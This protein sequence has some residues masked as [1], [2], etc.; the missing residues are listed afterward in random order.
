MGVVRSSRLPPSL[1]GKPILAH[2]QQV[3]G[4]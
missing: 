3:A 2:W 4:S 1:N